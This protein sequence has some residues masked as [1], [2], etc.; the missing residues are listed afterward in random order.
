MTSA[1]QEHKVDAIK[2]SVIIVAGL[3]ELIL[4]IELDRN[5][6]NHEREH[7]A[8][9]TIAYIKQVRNKYQNI[10]RTKVTIDKN[11]NIIP[12]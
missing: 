11:G 2:E 4:T 9:I 1:E 3:N 6:E 5:P 8:D 10:A 7:L 12:I